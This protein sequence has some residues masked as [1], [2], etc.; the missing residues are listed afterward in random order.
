[1]CDCG[2]KNKRKSILKVQSGRTQSR[3]FSKIIKI[4]KVDFLFSISF[5]NNCGWTEHWSPMVYCRL[6]EG[7]SAPFPITNDRFWSLWPW[8][9]ENL[10]KALIFVPS[11]FSVIQNSYI[12][13]LCF[14]FKF[15]L[16]N[17]FTI[18]CSGIGSHHEQRKA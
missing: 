12:D 11:L 7:F 17:Y 9:V 3:K 1:M 15:F 16:L 2:K 10:F 5:V 8:H 18:R 14:C 4:N 13:T 6:G